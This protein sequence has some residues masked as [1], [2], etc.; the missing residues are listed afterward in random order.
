M[1]PYQGMRSHELLKDY[2]PIEEK[3]EP[4][5]IGK[6]KSQMRPRISKSNKSPND[7]VEPESSDQL[8][9]TNMGHLYEIMKELQT[10]GGEQDRQDFMKLQEVLDFMSNSENPAGQTKSKDKEQIGN[11]QSSN[12]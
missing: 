4:K 10:L 3:K 9:E 11:N 7:L 12:E 8:W 6:G 1:V 2:S 5:K